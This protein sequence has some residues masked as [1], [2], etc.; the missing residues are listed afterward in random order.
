MYGL[1]EVFHKYAVSGIP[2]EEGPVN[3]F[4]FMDHKLVLIL[5]FESNVPLLSKI[6]YSYVRHPPNKF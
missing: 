3:R 5:F 4:A 1:I 2:W 6:L